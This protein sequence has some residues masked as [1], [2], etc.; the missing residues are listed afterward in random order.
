M[1]LRVYRKNK[2]VT[3]LQGARVEGTVSPSLGAGVRLGE[4]PRNT[5]AAWPLGPRLPWLKPPESL[6]LTSAIAFCSHSNP[7]SP[8]ARERS[9]AP[10]RSQHST[11]SNPGQLAKSKPSAWLAKPFTTE[12]DAQAVAA[13]SQTP[14]PKHGPLADEGHVLQAPGWFV[15]PHSPGSKEVYLQPPDAGGRRAQLPGLWTHPPLRCHSHSRAPRGISPRPPSR[16]PS[17]CLTCF[18]S[19]SLPRAL[20]QKTTY[21]RSPPQALFLELSPN[22]IPTSAAFPVPLAV[23]A[24]AGMHTPRP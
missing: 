20:L 24:P 14:S 15:H 16:G 19:Q 8:A 18:P 17:P 23:R 9:Q 13:P 4:G 10:V 11:T 1:N 2:K 7:L 6:P 21:T 22:R 3:D 12:T 5:A